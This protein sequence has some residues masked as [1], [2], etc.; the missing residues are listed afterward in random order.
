MSTLYTN[1]AKIKADAEKV[2]GVVKLALKDDV[3]GV[4]IS[5]TTLTVSKTY[6]AN[7]KDAKAIVIVAKTVFTN[8]E[9]GELETTINLADISGTWKF[10]TR[11][12]AF[13]SDNLNNT[14]NLATSASWTDYRGQAMWTGGSETDITKAPGKDAWGAAPLSV[15]GFTAPTFAVATDDVN[16]KYVSVTTDG[17]ISLTQAGKNLATPVTVIVN[18]NVASNWGTIDGY[19]AAKTITVTVDLSKKSEAPAAK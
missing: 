14:L 1:Y 11:T 16:A 8:K 19:A 15:Y 12:A 5:G 10:D 3:K 6:D 9:Q 18:V 7:A 17:K 13:G 4:S 2:G